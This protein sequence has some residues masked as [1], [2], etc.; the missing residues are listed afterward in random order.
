M[1]LAR[2]GNGNSGDPMG[3]SQQGDA[4]RVGGPSR[5]GVDDAA[6]LGPHNSAGIALSDLEAVPF[7]HPLVD[8]AQHLV[9]RTIDHVVLSELAGS[10]EA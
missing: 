2:D 4:G 6:A 8:E 10:N 5:R 9:G 7:C 3:P 1:S